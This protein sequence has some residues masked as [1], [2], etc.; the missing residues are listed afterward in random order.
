MIQENA[1]KRVDASGNVKIGDIGIYLRDQI[2][3]RFSTGWNA[4]T[5][6]YIDPSYI[7]RSSPANSDDSIFCNQLARNAV[8]AGMSGRTKMVLG[9]WNNTF[10]HMPMTAVI[11]EKK[12]LD[13]TGS[14]WL[15]V[16]ETTGQPASL[17]N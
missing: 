10:T 7:I 17:K 14:E 4:A 13:P 5:V 9:I 8:H 15:S 11:S 12:Q 16:L 1:A 3:Q 6:K 2:S